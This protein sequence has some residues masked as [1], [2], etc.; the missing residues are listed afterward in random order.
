MQVCLHA[1]AELIASVPFFEDAEE[2]FVT[3]LVTLLHPQ[4]SSLAHASPGSSQLLLPD[5]GNDFSSMFFLTF[6][7]L[8]VFH[9]W[10]LPRETQS[11]PCKPLSSSPGRYRWCPVCHACLNSNASSGIRSQSRSAQSTGKWFHSLAGS[12]GR[13]NQAGRMTRW[14]HAVALIL[15]SY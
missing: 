8:I 9:L 3:S 10:L 7:A 6:G 2:G 15:S 5:A 1:C 14:L 13:S 4:V 12:T 11:N